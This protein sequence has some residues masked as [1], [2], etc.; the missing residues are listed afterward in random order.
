M[1]RG[2][3][4]L[5]N[6]TLSAGCLVLLARC[7]WRLKPGLEPRGRNSLTRTSGTVQ[8][9]TSAVHSPTELFYNL[10]KLVTPGISTEFLSNFVNLLWYLI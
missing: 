1:G 10:N 5:R 7:P 3:W 2:V 6:P 9:I 8:L 4:E